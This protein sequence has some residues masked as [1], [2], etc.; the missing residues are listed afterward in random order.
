[1]FVPAVISV[2]EILDKIKDTAQS[3]ARIQNQIGCE[4]VVKFSPGLTEMIRKTGPVSCEASDS[5]SLAL[6]RQ[7]CPVEKPEPSSYKNG[8]RKL[9]VVSRFP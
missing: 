1:M 8:R 6:T 3:I 9:S 5:V 7:I 4:G 2:V